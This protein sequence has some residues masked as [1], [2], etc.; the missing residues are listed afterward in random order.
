MQLCRLGYCRTLTRARQ[1]ICFCLLPGGDVDLIVMEVGLVPDSV[2]F[3][4]YWRAVNLVPIA[5]NASGCT[6][7]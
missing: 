4:V 7:A 3:F 1:R 5:S 2:L 6:A